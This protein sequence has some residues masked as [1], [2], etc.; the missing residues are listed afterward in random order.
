[1]L[2]LS[3]EDVE[4]VLDLDRL[5]D[6]LAAAMADLS[7]GRA[8]VPTR[9]A[10]FVGERQG[11]LAAMPAYLPS[12][13]ALTTKLVSLFPQNT[14]LPTHHAIIACFDPETGV[15]VALMDGT[16]ITAART[17]AGSALATKLLGR[18]GSAVVSVLGTGVQ[19][20]AHALALVRLPGV[21]VIQVAG[22]DQAKVAALTDEL[23]DAGVRAAAIASIEDAVRSADVVCASTHAAEPVVRRA[24]LR[25]G[26]HVNSVGYNMTGA[27]E[28]DTDT[29][30]DAMVVVESRD[31]VLAAPPSGAIELHRAIDAG[32]IDR[33]HIHA[34][35]GELVSGERPGRSDD[36]QLTLYKSVGVAVQDAAAAALVL[37]AARRHGI[38]HDVALSFRRG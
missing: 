13:G 1:V 36:T 2:V 17:A 33:D 15:P 9:I 31:A 27:G 8:D 20:R 19:G 26:T 29:V 12:A 3:Q 30:R 37:E 5:V 4:S 35:I 34:E 38:G 24:W 7:Q 10:T 16:S 23:S 25:P 11:L 21:E 22:R 28:V 6:A 14:G 18:P 32:V